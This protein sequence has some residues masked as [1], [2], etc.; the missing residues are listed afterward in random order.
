MQAINPK[1]Q[2]FIDRIAAIDR[3]KPTHDPE[4]V[5]AAFKRRLAATR[6]AKNIR[7]VTDPSEVDGTN[8]AEAASPAA[9]FSWAAHAATIAWH[10]KTPVSQRIWPSWDVEVWISYEHIDGAISNAWRIASGLHA[11]SHHPTIVPASAAHNAREV[12]QDVRETLNYLNATDRDENLSHLIDAYE[13]MLRAAENGAFVYFFCEHEIIVLASPAVWTSDRKLHRADGPSLE[14]PKTKLYYWRGGPVPAWFFLDK[15]KITGQAIKT[16]LDA[17]LRRS[18]CEIVGWDVV[19]KKIGVKVLAFDELN[20]QRRELL[21]SDALG[22]KFIR[23][24]GGAAGPCGGSREFVAPVAR[25]A[26]T[27]REAVVMTSEVL[28]KIICP[29]TDLSSLGFSCP[30]NDLGPDE[31][32]QLRVNFFRPRIRPQVHGLIDRLNAIDWTHPPHDPE[33]VVAAFKKRLVATGLTKNVCWFADPLD[34]TD[35]DFDGV[36]TDRKALLAWDVRSSIALDDGI[37][38]GAYD[39]LSAWKFKCAFLRWMNV[40]LGA[41][42]RHPMVVSDDIE[43]A[44]RYLNI[45]DTDEAIQRLIH[46]Y[47]PMISAFEGGAFAYFLCEKDIIVVA[48]PGIWTSGRE[49]QQLHRVDGPALEWPKAKLYFWRGTPVPD[50]FIREKEKITGQAIAAEE[51]PEYRHCMCEIIGWDNAAEQLVAKV[52]ATDEWK[53]QRRELLESVE[54]RLKFVRIIYAWPDGIRRELVLPA[55]YSATTPGEAMANAMGFQ[56]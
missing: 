42:S 56:S 28:A 4:K 44:I 50:W 10:A 40:D 41:N 32:N 16:E 17:E 14:W 34:L 53:G 20:G 22:Q 26:R 2:G 54:A 8:C 13:P 23:I 55:S 46:V 7:W 51:L 31:I 35:N 39:L 18:M 12:M 25:S 38:P 6:L 9:W 3:T 47:E 19:I 30:A 36:V 5:I 24:I 33:K 27:P 11:G 52:I 29:A 43:A 21:K 48:S 15:E 49:L 45:E 37:A 1:V